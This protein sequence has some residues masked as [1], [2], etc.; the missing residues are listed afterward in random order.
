MAKKSKD[1]KKGKG[2]LVPPG[3]AHMSD[4][5]DFAATAVDS[6]VRAIRKAITDLRKSL[7]DS[8]GVDPTKYKHIIRIEPKTP[9][10]TST[11][12]GSCGCGCS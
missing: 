1:G 6:D 7:F 11:K 4:F 8:L 2:G 12:S 5:S 9:G 10:P 3:A